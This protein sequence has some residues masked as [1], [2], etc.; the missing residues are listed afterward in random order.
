MKK[1][2]ILFTAVC[3]LTVAPI[4]TSCQDDTYTGERE[5]IY[6]YNLGADASKA[7][8]QIKASRVLS[9]NADHTLKSTWEEDDSIMAYVTNDG[10]EADSY[11][12]ITN[13]DLGNSSHF[14]GKINAKDPITTSSNIAFF[15]PGKATKGND[16]TAIPVVLHKDRSSDYHEASDKIQDLLELNLSKQDGTIETIGKRFDFQWAKASPKTINGDEIKA[17]LK[18]M[19]RIISVWGL[20]FTDNNNKPLSEIDSVYISNVNSSD[21]FDLKEGK[22][23]ENNSDDERTNIV[24]KPAAGKKLSSTGGKYTYAALLPDTYENVIVMVYTGS[25]IYMRVYPALTFKEDN[26]YRSDLLKMEEPKQQPSVEVEGIKWATGN[27][28]HYKVDAQEYWG[29]APAQWWISKYAVY[30]DDKRKEKTT[31]TNLVSSQFVDAP[32]QTADDV[33]LFR[34]GAIA[35]ALN[36]N[37]DKFKSGAKVDICKT[38]YKTDL[39]TDRKTTDRANAKFGDIAWYYTMYN[40]KKYRYPTEEELLTLY[41]KA[42]VEPAYC[43]TDKGTLVYGAYYTTNRAG[44]DK[45]KVSFPTGVRAYDKYK[46]VTALIRANIG[47]FLPITGARIALNDGLGFRDMTWGSGAYGQYMNAKGTSMINTKYLRFGPN[48][49]K[50]IDFRKVQTSALRPVL[51]SDD[52]EED[53]AFAPFAHIK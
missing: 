11:S 1:R 47:L 22:Y 48:D 45:R 34:F 28:I 25:K 30:I 26:V 13:K 50:I 40:H 32:V 27:F 52:G 51:D 12:Y 5:R 16:R 53:P 6:T 49:W 31:G 37:D 2:N 23:L 38:F 42:N 21:V 18:T 35:T 46:N 9:E 20:R 4:L 36:L 19:K 44:S 24:I 10:L 3:L 15:Y 8:G 41:D 7:L 33:D 17:D 29:I 43:Y 14:N 39:P